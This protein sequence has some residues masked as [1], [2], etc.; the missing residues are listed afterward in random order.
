M[1]PRAR[2]L[3]AIALLL[4]VAA[5][6]W[7]GAVEPLRAW[8]AAAEA[9]LAET[10]A[11]LARH[12]AIAARAD[13]IAAEAAALRE[14]ATREALFLPGATEGQAAAALQEAIK[15]AAN[16]AGARPD[17]VQALETTEDAGLLRVA[18]RVRLSADVASLQKLLYALEADRPIV[19]LENLYVRARSLRA[20]G[21][22]RNLDVRFDV[23]GFAQAGGRG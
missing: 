1:T 12:R 9:R 23:V 7:F 5:V 17:S 8:R 19:L 16:A 21:D 22:E 11:A 2:R 6:V 14:I 3:L 4:G 18:M 10:E 15:A 20:D 13:E